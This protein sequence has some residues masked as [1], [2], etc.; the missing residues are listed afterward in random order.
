MLVGE[1]N[2]VGGTKQIELDPVDA[3]GPPPYPGGPLEAR[4]LR[5]LTRMQYRKERGVH[6]QGLRIAHQ[7]GQDGS[8]QG[9]QI[10]PQLAYPPMKRGGPTVA[11]LLGKPDG[12]CFISPNHATLI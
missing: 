2:A 5:D 12:L 1:G 11:L 3:E 7:L 4:A 10:T 6:D 9:L 8:P